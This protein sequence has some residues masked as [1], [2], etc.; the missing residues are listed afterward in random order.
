MFLKRTTDGVWERSPQ[1]TEGMRVWGPSAQ[2]V[3]NLKKEA[4]LMPLDHISLVFRTIRK[5]TRFLTFESQ[6]KKLNDLILLLFA[7]CPKHV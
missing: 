2:Q 5:K 7:I 1:R 6:L 4:F 3:V